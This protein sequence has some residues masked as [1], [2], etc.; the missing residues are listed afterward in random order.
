MNPD[1]ML[2]DVQCLIDA[3]GQVPAEELPRVFEHLQQH[4][5]VLAGHVG[6]RLT[7]IAGR[8]ALSGAPTELVQGMHHDVLHL[9]LG[10]LQA[11]RLGHYRL[12]RDCVS[13]ERLPAPDVPPP[14]QR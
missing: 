2:V 4:E 14:A 5:P 11:L 9:I 1:A 3:V 6:A 8:L 7:T 10:T 12:W 13:A